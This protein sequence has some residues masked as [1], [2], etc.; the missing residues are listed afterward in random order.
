MELTRLKSSI[1]KIGKDK[2]DT[3]KINISTNFQAIRLNALTKIGILYTL[4]GYEKKD[5]IEVD[6]EEIN[7]INMEK[8]G[9]LNLNFSA[10]P[11]KFDI[12][13]KYTGSKEK[14][15]KRINKVI[16][17]ILLFSGGVDSVAGLLYCLDSKLKVL[18]IWID[19]GQKNAKNERKSVE[20]IIK[21]MGVELLIVNINLKKYVYNG[22]DDW[23]M[24]IIPARNFLFLVF[25]ELFISMTKNKK[26]DIF[27]CGGKEE[28]NKHH[29][30]KSPE[31]YALASKLLSDYSGK[32]IR[33][34]TPFFNFNKTEILK[35]WDKKWI[36]K[37]GVS[38]KDTITCYLGK[39][40]GRCS[41]CYYR[42]ISGITAGVDD[43]KFLTEPLKDKGRIIRDYYFKKF[44]GWDGVR[45]TD[46]IIA[47]DKNKNI[48]H[49]E[50]RKFYDK[51]IIN[52]KGLIKKRLKV[53][54]KINITR[55]KVEKNLD[56]FR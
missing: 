34:T 55:K 50:I 24:G 23:K 26:V 37:F 42:R 2:V 15:S 25:A 4:A 6:S 53:L 3:N 14:P 20:N 19:F 16:D 21:R 39:N 10:A 29:N 31:F 54:E 32:E 41:A 1:G 45:K 22:W 12:K 18:P 28:I 5:K 7:V 33:V 38:L 30:D 49:P 51:H 13:I 36:K 44:K 56:F 47:L 48:L 43:N 17:V 35:Y 8:F 27:L 11:K 52:F 9:N 46:F 40:C